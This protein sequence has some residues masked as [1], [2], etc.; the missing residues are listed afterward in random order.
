MRLH[1]REGN[2]DKYR[3]EVAWVSPSDHGAPI[4]LPGCIYSYEPQATAYVLVTAEKGVVRYESTLSS[5]GI[6]VAVIG[7]D[8]SSWKCMLSHNAVPTLRGPDISFIRRALQVQR[9]I[10]HSYSEYIPCH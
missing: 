8:E 10:P 7:A 2:E 6:S 1:L 9:A 3:T 4:R 5:C